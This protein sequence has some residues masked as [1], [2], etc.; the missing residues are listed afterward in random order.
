[1][2]DRIKRKREER[3]KKERKEETSNG[4]RAKTDRI[5]SKP[6][7]ITFVMVKWVQEVVLG[8]TRNGIIVNE[9]SRSENVD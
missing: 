5:D 2:R 9:P 4:L 3:E 8:S 1:M 6:V 7:G